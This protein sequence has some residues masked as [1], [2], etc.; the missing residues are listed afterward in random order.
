VTRPRA[1]AARLTA[2]PAAG[3]SGDLDGHE[4]AQEGRCEERKTTELA[5]RVEEAW[6]QGAAATRA[7]PW[8]PWPPRPHI[9]AESEQRGSKGVE[10]K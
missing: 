5:A 3:R 10:G 4:G 6:R 8:W 7:W 9:G 1:P 2:P